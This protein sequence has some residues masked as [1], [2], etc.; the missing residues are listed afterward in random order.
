[1]SKDQIEEFLSFMGFTNVVENA[2][3]D[4]FEQN[5]IEPVIVG[6]VKTLA[7]CLDEEIK[8]PQFE[9]NWDD[10]PSWA[11]KASIRVH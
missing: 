1:M 6:L 8:N 5:P 3:T 11:V 2:I 10:A 9:P 7:E 4:Y